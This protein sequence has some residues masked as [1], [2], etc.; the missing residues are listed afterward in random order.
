MTLSSGDRFTAKLNVMR[1]GTACVSAGNETISVGPVTCEDGTQVQL[2]YLGERDLPNMDTSYAICLSQGVINPEAYSKYLNEI[3]D[4]LTP[5]G[6]PEVGSIT[7]LEIEKI[8][9]NGIGYA[10]VGE[11][12]LVVGPTT[13]AEDD[14]VQVE[15]VTDSHAKILDPDLQGEDYESRFW[16][17]SG[18]SHKLP[19]S[20]TEEYTTAVAEFNGDTR[21]CY[22]K[23]IPIRVKNCDAKLGQKLDVEITGFKQDIVAGTAT[24]IYDEVVRTN[25]PGHWARM[26]WLREAGIVDPPLQSVASEFIGIGA[27]YLPEETERLKTALIGESIR[28]CLADK[29][30]DSVEEYPRAH[31]TGIHHWIRHKLRAIVGTADDSEGDWFREVLDE[32]DGPTLTF[33]GDIIKLSQGY[34]AVGPTRTIPV[35]DSTAILVSGLP[36]EHFLQK[37]LDVELRGLSRAVTNA[38]ESKLRDHGLMIQSQEDYIGMDHSEYDKD[39]L[40]DFITGSE[41]AEWQ[42]NA[43]WE[44]F[45]GERGFGL[46]WGDDPLEAQIDSD[47]DITLW[48]EPV[49]YGMDEFHIRVVSNGDVAG[50]RLPQSKYKQ[51]CLLIESIA[52]TP[53][54]VG[55][56]D[57]PNQNTVQLRCTF[58]PPR[59]QFR[60][61]TAIGA[62]WR[63]FE[64]DR[65][66]WVVPEEAVE[67]IIRVFEQL[68]VNILDDR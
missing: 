5:E 51:F 49:E 54:T 37:G 19:I 18:Q 39:H 20:I 66:Q 52:D 1:S 46:S 41:L 16:I 68:P 36:T 45:V 34:Y 32:G 60:W 64:N 57:T 28:L 21:I 8:D 17:L 42:A 22:V 44:S 4:I 9:K 55:I 29:A 58:S 14:F 38:S 40:A 26:Q 13:V 59:A 67:S 7:Y 6:T 61:L 12:Q 43:E 3:I 2:K 27:N 50:L 33:Q 10:S 30:E 53:R 48:R 63:G 11:S 23:N 35:S 65:I 62:D 15:M 56:L 31:I 24:E 47:T 25:N